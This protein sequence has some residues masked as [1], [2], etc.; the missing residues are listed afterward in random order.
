MDD[1]NKDGGSKKPE[2]DEDADMFADLEEEFRDGDED[3]EEGRAGKKKAVR[4]LT[5]MK[6]RDRL[7]VARVGGIYLPTLRWTQRGSFR[8]MLGMMRRAVM[9]RRMLP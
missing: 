3:E 1:Y 8:R 9:M 5:K 4:F 2:V 6:S 7:L